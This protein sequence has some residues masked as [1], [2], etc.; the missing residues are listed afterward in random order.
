M[1]CYSS[2]PIQPNLYYLDLTRF[3]I[4][5]DL[6]YPLSSLQNVYWIF[7]YFDCPRSIS[8]FDISLHS[9]QA[10][11]QEY[12]PDILSFPR[13]VVVQQISLLQ[14]TRHQ[15]GAKLLRIPDYQVVP[16]LT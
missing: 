14:L 1:L 13:N 12:I 4:M 16:I 15:T 3:K 6:F 2:R 5:S 9:Q 8:A 10:L 11:Q 7:L